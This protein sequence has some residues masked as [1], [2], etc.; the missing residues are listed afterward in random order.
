MENPQ[1][2]LIIVPDTLLFAIPS[3]PDY[4]GDYSSSLKEVSAAELGIGNATWKSN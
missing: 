1:N 4:P 3:I 2:Q